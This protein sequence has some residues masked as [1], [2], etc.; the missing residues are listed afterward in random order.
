MRRSKA[1]VYLH[2]VWS[3]A[4]RKQWLT[5]EIEREVH[6]CIQ[7]EACRLGCVVLGLNGMPDH[8]HLVVQVPTT[9]SIAHLVKQIKGVSSTFINDH[10]EVEELFRWQEHY[11]VFSLSRSHLNRVVAYVKHQKQQ[12]AVGRVWAAWEET[13]A[14]V[15]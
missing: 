9:V 6:R 11:A 2:L 7:H 10:L 5:P 8:V 12:H 3:T 4:H 14:E 15:G 13:D 1:E